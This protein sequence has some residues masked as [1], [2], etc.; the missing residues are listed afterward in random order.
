M[1]REWVAA[2]RTQIIRLFVLDFE[3][4]VFLCGLDF[5]ILLWVVAIDGSF[6]FLHAN[7]GEHAYSGGFGQFSER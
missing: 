1:V 2:G 5:G 3:R 4:S 6:L 7:L